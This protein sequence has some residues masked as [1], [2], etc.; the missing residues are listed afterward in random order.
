[1]SFGNMFISK[2][3]IFD[4]YSKWLFEILHIYELKIQENKMNIPPRLLEFVAQALLNIWVDMNPNKISLY[5]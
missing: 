5:V 3:E 4:A 2:K 1:M